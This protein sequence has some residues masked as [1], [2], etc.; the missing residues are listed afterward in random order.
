MVA[1]SATPDTH[2]TELAFCGAHVSHEE[3]PWRALVMPTA[4]IGTLVCDVLLTG[5]VCK[6]I[7]KTLLDCC[8]LWLQ[9]AQGSV[10][11]VQLA[12]ARAHPVVQ[13]AGG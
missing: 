11:P 10:L 3:I 1:W 8:R 7:L 12:A 2:N 5:A 9:G 13:G 6:G 4:A